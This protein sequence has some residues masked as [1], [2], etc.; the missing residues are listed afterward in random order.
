MGLLTT[1]SSDYSLGQPEVTNAGNGQHQGQE[2]NNI[3]SPGDASSLQSGVRPVRMMPFK[4]MAR[5]FYFGKS[6]GK[7]IIFIY[8]SAL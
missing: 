5:L 3:V 1:K 6:R 8:S 7:P 4:R 2:I